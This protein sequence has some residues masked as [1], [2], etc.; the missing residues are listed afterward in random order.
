M[1][2]RTFAPG[3][4]VRFADDHGGNYDRSYRV[5]FEWDEVEDTV[6]MKLTISM[7]GEPEPEMETALTSHLVIIGWCDQDGN[8]TWA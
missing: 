2:K 8:M 5:V 3:T 4:V 6:E 7:P 1:I